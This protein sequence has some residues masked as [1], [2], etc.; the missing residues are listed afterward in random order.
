MSKSFRVWDVDQAWLLPPSI[1]E[2]VRPGH[3][4]HFVRDTVREALDLSAI[5]GVYTAEQ[6]QPPY[7]PGMLVALLLY[8]Y[9]RGI[10]SSR[11]LARACEERLDVMAVTGLNRPDFRTISDFRKRHLAALAGLFVE[12]LRLCQ[13]AG[14][15]RL[16]HVAV[17]GTKLRANA[18]KHKAMSYGRMQ[19][20]EPKLAAEVKAWM[21]RAQAADDADDAE[22]GAD[23]RGDE[24]PD[25]MA[26]KQ[27]RLERIRAAK[28]QLEAEAKTQPG[29]GDPD[30]PGPSSGM[31]QRGHRKQT[32]PAA[33]PDAAPPDPTP[34]DKAQRNFT[35]PDSRIMPSGGGFIA[36]YNGQI[37]VEAEHQIITAQRVSTNPADFDALQPLVDATIDALGKAPSEVSGDT[38]FA[39][40]ANLHAMDARGVRPYLCPGRLRHGSTDPEARRVLKRTPR[41][42]KMADTI[43]RAGRRSRYRLRKQ[44]VEPVFGQIKHA[45]GFRQFL[46]R[47]LDKVRGE[48][49]M[50]C[51]AHNL[52]KLHQATA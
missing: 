3:L 9:S 20:E 14:L 52:T 44:V 47:G 13:A 10:Y 1:H 46:L 19:Q 43:R 2:F 37:A 48:W 42:Q 17:D 34:P 6:G 21:D 30:G 22:H 26:N 15:V 50:V 29:A 25:W 28:A 5:T 4:A 31:Q 12:V 24:M 11:Q 16:G 23:R 35:D 33:P 51:T 7:H 27:R 49:A 41:M 40:E 45:R 18:S 8:G 39:S 32:E 38:G 36:G